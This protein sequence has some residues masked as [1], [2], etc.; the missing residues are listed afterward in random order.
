MR[1]KQ[2][3]E[4]QQ[5]ISKSCVWKTKVNPKNKSTAVISVTT[6]QW[7]TV[8]RKLL[9][10]CDQYVLLVLA[11]FSIIDKKSLSLKIGKKTSMIQIVT[12]LFFT[13]RGGRK[14]WNP[15]QKKAEH[16]HNWESCY[17]KYIQVSTD[18]P[19]RFA[20]VDHSSHIQHFTV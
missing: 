18:I 8:L 9:A 2:L 19:F 15:S 4:L 12:V 11:S 16:F 17:T 3:I 10:P 13:Y 1:E 6:S 14:Q 5:Q 7:L 20:N